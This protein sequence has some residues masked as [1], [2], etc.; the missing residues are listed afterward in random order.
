M[1]DVLYAK[2][3]G[4]A[5]DGDYSVASTGSNSVCNMQNRRIKLYFSLFLSPINLVLHPLAFSILISIQSCSLF[6]LLYSSYAV[7]VT[8][9]AKWEGEEGGRGERGGMKD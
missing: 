7:R 8:G 6:S 5:A 1:I 3:D 9:I 4:D 2:I